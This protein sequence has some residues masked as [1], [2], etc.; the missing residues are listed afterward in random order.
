MSAEIALATPLLLLI[1]LGIVQFAL[2]SH[3]THIA[4]AAATEG[5]AAARVH[6]GTVADGETR[7][8]AVV[9]ELG[10]GPI[11]D[12]AVHASRTVEQARV[13]VTGVAATVVPFLQLPIHAEAAGAVERFVPDP[14]N[15]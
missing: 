3:G 15:R 6:S 2:W 9:D 13:E 4:Q 8:R 5:L 11:R 12:I 10:D 14:T 7:A 1:L